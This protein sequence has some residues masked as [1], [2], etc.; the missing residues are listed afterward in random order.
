MRCAC[1]GPPA[2]R[3]VAQQAPRATGAGLRYTVP[4]A[5][6]S[7]GPR[8]AQPGA[9]VHGG[10]GGGGPRRALTDPGGG[11]QRAYGDSSLRKKGRQAL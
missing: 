1:T 2:P 11:R 3:R 5:S 9:S 6:V 8:A 10:G 7:G 4:A